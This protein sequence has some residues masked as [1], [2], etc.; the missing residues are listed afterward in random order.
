M[1]ASR[2]HPLA[3]VYIYDRVNEN[4][5]VPLADA[6]YPLIVSSIK[7]SPGG[8]LSSGNHI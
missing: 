2:I 8:E 7:S 3:S 5:L 4:G 6:T 1:P